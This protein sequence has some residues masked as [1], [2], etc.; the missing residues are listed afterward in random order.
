LKKTDS[1]TIAE[2]LLSQFNIF[3]H[4]K[5]IIN[6]NAAN[7]TSEILKEIYRVYGMEIRNIPVYR[8]ESNS[9][10]ERS[11]AV[12]N[13]ILKKL[14]VEQPRQWHRYIDPLL[15]AIRTTENSN[16]FTP[17][18][19]L[20]G[21]LPHTHL[22]V[23]KNLWTDQD[24]DPETKTTYQYVLDLRNRIEETCELAQKQIT[25]THLSNVKRLNKY[26]KLRVLSPGDKVL[27]LS[28]KPKNKLD[29]IWKGPA[30]V[31]KR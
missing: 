11:H 3:G 10:Q 15:L 29:F 25:K 27:V 19:L 8:P 7:L 26:A 1:V 28:P 2:A 14:C 17:F 5:R 21:R 30:E 24:K 31:I 18:E 9:I 16:G 6:D 4:R 23:L 22:S 20:Y 13:G 12:I